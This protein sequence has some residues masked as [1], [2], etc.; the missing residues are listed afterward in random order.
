MVLLA[1]D[2]A[3]FNSQR[4]GYLPIERMEDILIGCALALIG[5]TAA[6]LR[7]MLSRAG[8]SRPG[9]PQRAAGN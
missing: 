1:F 9:P 7:A 6:F 5:T 2:L 4:V 8:R 3:Q